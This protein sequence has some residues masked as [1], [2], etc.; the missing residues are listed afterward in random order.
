MAKAFQSRGHGRGEKTFRTGTQAYNGLLEQ[1]YCPSCD[2]TR[3]TEREQDKGSMG[4]GK[5]ASGS[6][7]KR[8]LSTLTQ[9]ISE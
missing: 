3:Q 7:F 5:E 2:R 6:T 1:G 4:A 9:V 8:F